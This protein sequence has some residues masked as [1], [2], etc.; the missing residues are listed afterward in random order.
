MLECETDERQVGIEVFYTD[1]E[2]LGG[3]LKIEPEDFVVEERSLPPPPSDGEHL[4]MKIAARNWETNRLVRHLARALRVSRKR[5]GFAGMKDKRAVTTQTISLHVPQKEGRLLITPEQ[6]KEMRISDFKVLD[7]YSSN[8]GIETG[9]LLGNSFDILIGNVQRPKEDAKMI[10]EETLSQ[11]RPLNGFPNF[12]GIQRFGALRPVTHR[13]GE[14]IIRGDFKEAVFAYIAN[15]I[16][17]E[18]E[19]SYNARRTLAENMDFPEA[20]RLFPKSLSF[21]KAVVNQLVHDRE[22]YAGALQALPKNLLMMFVHAYQ[23][24]LFNRILSQRIREGLPLNE[25]VLGDIVLPTDKEG[26]SEEDSR[27]KVTS[28]NLNKVAKRVWEGK[29]RISGL[30]YGSESVF[31]EGEPGEIERRTIQNEKIEAKHFIVPEIPKISSKGTRRS[32]LSH[33]KDMDWRIEEGGVRMKFQL[34]KG[35]YATALLR[36]FMKANMTD[37]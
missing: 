3:K 37:Y 23:S 20:L 5:I 21:E 25:P 1:S 15:P 19:E 36:E 30:V 7:V 11:L 34:T 16:E 22:N 6:V 24:Y 26:I 31:A 35:C 9:E 28:N 10:V 18:P 4:I 13:V 8:R 12:F 27:I 14:H 29:A 32:L 2:P 33:F 17:G